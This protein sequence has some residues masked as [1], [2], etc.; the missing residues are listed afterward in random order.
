MLN[1]LVCVHIEGFSDPVKM[2]PRGAGELTS[3]LTHRT[4]IA[5]CKYVIAVRSNDK[6]EFRVPSVAEALKGIGKAFRSR[7]GL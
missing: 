1:D 2:R 7:Y 3:D 4:R 6:V 5:L